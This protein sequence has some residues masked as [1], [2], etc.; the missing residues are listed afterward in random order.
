MATEG[1]SSTV[2]L[3]AGTL[4]LTYTDYSAGG[5]GSS[6][7][8]F[9]VL[10][11]GAGPAS[12]SSLASDLSEHGRVVV[13]ILPGF[14]G[15][16]RP[17]WFSSVPDLALA[18]LALIERLQ[19]QDVAV[20][21]SSMGGWIAA[22]IGLRACPKVASL[23]LLNAGGIDMDTPGWRMPDPTTLPPEQRGALTFHDPAKYGRSILPPGPNP[24]AAMP[25]NQLALRA[26]GGSGDSFMYSPTLRA[27]LSAMQPAPPTLLLWG[28]SDRICD[29][30]YGELYASSIPSARF[31]PIPEAGHFPHVEQ[32]E[33][34]NKHLTQFLKL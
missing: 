28:E 23:V 31:T 18:C 4:P 19:L 30:K 32:R 16:P 29:L 14:A 33:L 9:L 20:L 13:P 15:T 24:F 5:S 27:R 12:V 17:G 2:E 6:A 8:S 3:F 1:K 22:E 34:V 11:G 25:G 7:R 26:Y 21:G 10:H